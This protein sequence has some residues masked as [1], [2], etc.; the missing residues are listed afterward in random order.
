MLRKIVLISI[1]VGIAGADGYYRVL[2][3][4]RG[5]KELGA[6]FGGLREAS[7]L[8]GAYV[9]VG[10]LFPVVIDYVWA[11]FTIA[12]IC[13]VEALVARVLELVL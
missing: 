8:D 5:G 7:A 9:W 11:A 3:W 10:E 2:K 6:R 13:P 4:I 1:V 12:G